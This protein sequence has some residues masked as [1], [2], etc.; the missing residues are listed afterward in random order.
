MT[1]NEERYLSEVRKC[2]LRLA[3]DFAIKANFF[4]SKNEYEKGLAASFEED[5]Q[6]VFRMADLNAHY[7]IGTLDK[8]AFEENNVKK[9][10]DYHVHIR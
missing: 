3:Y 5:L 9:M 8:K 1:E 2:S 6:D 4:A 10:C 7:I